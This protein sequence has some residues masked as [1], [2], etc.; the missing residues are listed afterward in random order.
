VVRKIFLAIATAV[1]MLGIIEF[2]FRVYDSRARAEILAG[3]DPERLL[4]EMADDGRIYKLRPNRRG[5]TNSHGFRD[6]PRRYRKTPGTYRIA[7]IGDSV[8]MQST[9]QFEDLYATRLRR[10]LADMLP[11]RR[12]EI[13]NF[14]VTGY[15]TLQELAL[16]HAE[17]LAFR[18][19]TLLWQFHLNDA[20]DPLVDGGDGGLG[21]YYSRPTS[22][23]LWS[24]QRRWHR[25]Q[26]ARSIRARGLENVPSDLQHQVYRW[27]VIG[28]AFRDVAETAAENGFEVYVFIYPTWPRED[29]QEY[30]PAGFAV[31]DDLVARFESFGFATLDLVEVFRRESPSKYRLAP[32]DPWHPNRAGH[33][34]IAEELSLW[35]APR[36]SFHGS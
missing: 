3:R 14:G 23:V 26:R 33:E 12:I 28:D 20:I 36:L 27:R 10:E 4:T 15:G 21:K 24:L 5:K 18:P 13:L 1:M 16:L 2:G 19:D 6:L 17:V 29:W 35:L 22:A 7:V 8:T 31:V 34:V 30:S 9:M 11:G 25:F 32:D